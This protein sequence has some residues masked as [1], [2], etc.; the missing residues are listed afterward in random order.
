MKKKTGRI[1]ENII[2]IDI[3]TEIIIKEDTLGRIKEEIL[4]RKKIIQVLG[5]V[6]KE[7]QLKEILDR[8]MVRT[9]KEGTAIR[10]KARNQ[11]EKIKAP[12]K[13]KVRIH[14]AITRQILVAP[15]M[16]PIKDIID[17]N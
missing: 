3:T 11:E 9:L 12:G 14:K 1:L 13:I 10:I 17:H 5:R 6:K 16:G 7:I 2:D 4:G 15:T 8:T